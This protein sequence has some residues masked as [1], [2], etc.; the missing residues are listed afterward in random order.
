MPQGLT[1]VLEEW[2]GLE[3]E[4]QHAQVRNGV[5]LANGIKLFT[6]VYACYSVTPTWWWNVNDNDSN[7]LLYWND[8]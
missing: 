7:N 8:S 6:V 2:K 5:R 1:E 3:E 4:Y